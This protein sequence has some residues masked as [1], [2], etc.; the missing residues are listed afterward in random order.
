VGRFSGCLGLTENSGRPRGALQIP[1]LRFAT[2]GMTKGRA[3][4]PFRFDHADDEQQVPPL[5][6]APVGM[7]PLL[8]TNKERLSYGRDDTSGRNEQMNE[9]RD[10]ISAIGLDGYGGSFHANRKLYAGHHSRKHAH[11]E[12]SGDSGRSHSW[13]PWQS[14]FPGGRRRSSPGDKRFLRDRQS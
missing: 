7:T 3:A 5:R 12:Q 4:L 11:R 8:G 10:G 2:V 6:Y 14:A 9:K 13:L 1:P